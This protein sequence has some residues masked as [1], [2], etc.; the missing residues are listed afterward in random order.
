MKSKKYHWHVCECGRWRCEDQN[1][2]LSGHAHCGQK[3]AHDMNFCVKNRKLIISEAPAPAI[4]LKK[5]ARQRIKNK[6][7]DGR[8]FFHADT[9]GISETDARQVLQDFRLNLTNKQK[10]AK[11]NKA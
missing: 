5:F 10:K 3:K 4:L 11:V 9:F 7:T 1:C 8:F 2:N 6:I